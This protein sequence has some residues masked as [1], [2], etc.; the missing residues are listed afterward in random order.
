MV[1][2]ATKSSGICTMSFLDM[3]SETRC[4]QQAAIPTSVVIWQF[5][6]DTFTR[7]GNGRKKASVVDDRST[8]NSDMCDT[9]VMYSLAVAPPISNDLLL[10]RV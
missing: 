9:Q 5:T 8:L 2:S 6:R 7:F 1:L 4:V 10:S 3:S